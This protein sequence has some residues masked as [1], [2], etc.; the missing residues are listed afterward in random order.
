[1]TGQTEPGATIRLYLND[2]YVA[3]AV[4]SASGEVVFA[5]N[6]GVIAGNYRVR[7][8]Q[9]GGAPPQGLRAEQTVTVPAADMSLPI[10][11]AEPD[12]L[13]APG[14]TG[15]DKPVVVAAGS[16]RTAG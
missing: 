7:L 14:E 2:A 8:D 6:S 11:A 13:A 16:E 9:M 15:M 1:M 5:I 4:A 10:A 3:S 12:R